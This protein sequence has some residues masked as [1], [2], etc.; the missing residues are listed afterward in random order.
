MNDHVERMLDHLTT[1]ESSAATLPPPAFLRA[2]TRRRRRRAATKTSC[3]ACVLIGILWGTSVL[4]STAPSIPRADGVSDR[5]A[6]MD[7]APN[8]VWSLSRENTGRAPES[9]WLPEAAGSSGSIGTQPPESVSDLR[10]GRVS[11]EQWM[12]Q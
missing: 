12:L 11:I 8:S 6:V 9:L 4:R 5:V 10:R 7:L 2:V 3:A 1:R